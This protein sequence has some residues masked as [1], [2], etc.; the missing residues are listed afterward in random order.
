MRVQETR[1]ALAFVSW[2][3]HGGGRSPALLGRRYYYLFQQPIVTSP[4]DLEDREAC[5]RI[6]ADV[7]GGVQQGL[8]FLQAQ[9]ERD[10]YRDLPQ[11][12]LY[13][14]FNGKQAPT[15]PIDAGM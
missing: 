6:Y 12:L 13:E 4:A 8:A 10:P 1:K 14:A 15:F 11:R 2:R 7:K 3:E 5:D 9:R